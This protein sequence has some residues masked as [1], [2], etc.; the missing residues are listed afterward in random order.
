[1]FFVFAGFA[2]TLPWQVVTVGGQTPRIPRTTDRTN[3]TDRKNAPDSIR[4]FREIRGSGSYTFAAFA[5]RTAVHI[6][7]RNPSL[8]RIFWRKPIILI[9]FN[10]DRESRRSPIMRCWLVNLILVF[11]LML[12]LGAG[13]AYSQAPVASMVFRNDTNAPVIVQGTSIIGGMIRRGPPILVAP[14][15]ALGDFN[16]P[17]GRRF[18]SVYD[19]NQPSR[20]L[21]KDVPFDVP[22]GAS[23]IVAIRIVNNQ[24]VLVPE[25]K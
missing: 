18:Y 25:R 4:A 5:H 1:L 19:A 17:A 12:G 9:R 6:C 3:G 15:K 22:A 20:V 24:F 8:A 11:G 10:K 7:W 13:T 16:V 2:E 14:G 23:V 21:A